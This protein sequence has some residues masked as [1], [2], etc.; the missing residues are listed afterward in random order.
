MRRVLTIEVRGK[1]CPESEQSE[2]SHRTVK[3]TNNNS[4][5][6]FWLQHGMIRGKVEIR[7]KMCDLSDIKYN[8][9][10]IQ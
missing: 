7:P 8:F 5:R 4:T 1:S 10:L 2:P 3:E 9:Y 6:Q